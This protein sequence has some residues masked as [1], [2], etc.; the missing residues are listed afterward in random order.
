MADNQGM[1]MTRASSI[2]TIRF[3][4][5]VAAFGLVVW[6]S[7]PYLVHE[8]AAK[9]LEMQ[10]PSVGRPAPDFKL[11]NANGVQTSL[12][13]L[14][15]KVVLLNFWATWCGPCNTEVPWFV[16]FQ[17]RFGGRNF[18]V[19]GVSMDEPVEDVWSMI[20]PWA[21]ERKVNYPLLLADGVVTQA[22]GGVET[23]PASLLIDR[24]GIIRQI[25]IG[26]VPRETWEAEIAAL[27]GA[28]TPRP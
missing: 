8:V 4:A 13:A 21:A 9:I 16:D 7:R 22:Y 25:H 5:V 17:N 10:A 15:G 2:R 12:S 20:L 23:L 14:R 27:V 1:G 28:G 24:T 6:W 19:L 18:T 11:P 3:A 26:L